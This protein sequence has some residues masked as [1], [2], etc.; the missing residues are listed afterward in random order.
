MY[1]WFIEL[2]GDH[3]S[4]NEYAYWFPH[5]DKLFVVVDGDARFLTG[6][7]IW[8]IENPSL[9]RQIAI[10]AVEEMH[11]VISLLQPDAARPHVGIAW[12]L[13]ADGTK[14]WGDNT[15]SGGGTIPRPPRTLPADLNDIPTPT[16]GQILLAAMRSNR[17]LEL[18]LT[19]LVLPRATWPHLY[20]CLEEVELFLGKRASAAG[21]CT[22]NERDRFTR[23]AN[24]AEASGHDARHGLGK[25]QPPE[26]PMTPYEAKRFIGGIIEK[27]LDKVVPSGAA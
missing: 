17:H 4:T 8:T 3:V 9:A 5:G 14:I 10:Q 16:R 11:A 12:R 22:D 1:H 23:T 15:G 13:G 25:F 2:I 20:R 18:A 21:L 24:T 26:K 27:A 19:I 7:S 6:P